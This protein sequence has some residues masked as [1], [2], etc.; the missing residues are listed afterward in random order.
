MA[1]LKIL[2]RLF[3][4]GQ[5]AYKKL[6]G[7]IFDATIGLVREYHQKTVTLA[8]ITAVSFYLHAIKALRSAAIVLFL[9]VLVSAVFAV[10]LVMVP[11]VLILISPLTMFYKV[12][13]ISVLGIVEVGAP[14]LLL[15]N[16]FSEGRWMKFTKSK[17]LVDSIVN[18]SK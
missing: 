5:T 13:W 18:P 11:I 9:V 15:S 10:A 4:P 14:L 1:L 3:E 16:L 2:S 6:R 12:F 17:E 7:L 8:R